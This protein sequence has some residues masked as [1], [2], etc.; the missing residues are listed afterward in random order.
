M[1]GS[2]CRSGRT[3]PAFKKPR[4][5]LLSQSVCVKIQVRSRPGWVEHKV[6]FRIV[7]IAVDGSNGA[8]LAA[9]HEQTIEVALVSCHS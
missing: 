2:A 1:I 3:S 8:P 4:G 6:W 5:H 7:H 9:Y